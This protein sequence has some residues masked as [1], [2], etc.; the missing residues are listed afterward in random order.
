VIQTSLATEIATK[1]ITLFLLHVCKN[2]QHEYEKLLQER[3]NLSHPL[4]V[5]FGAD[6]SRNLY[7]T[8]Q[9]IAKG[10]GLSYHTNTKA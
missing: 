2:G 7:N 5:K 9:Y 10:L 6:A 8:Y 3:S 4:K 1:P